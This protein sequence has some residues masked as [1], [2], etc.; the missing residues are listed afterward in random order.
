VDEGDIA[1]LL[2]VHATRWSVPGAALGILH[3]GTVSTACFGVA[4]VRSNDPVTS[5]T[6][7]SAGSLTKSIVATHLL[8]LARA[9][10]LTLDDPV[11]QHVPELRGARWASSVTVRDLMANRSGLPLRTSLEFGF[12]DRLDEDDGAL[13]RLV[14]DLPRDEAATRFWSYTNVGWCVL[15]RVIETVTGQSFEEALGHCLDDLGMRDTG[16]G[17]AV[18]ARARGHSVTETGVA[19]VE[20]LASKAYAPAG[21]RLVTTVTDL[22]AFARHHLDDPSLA[23]L[24]TLHSEVAIRGWLDG[25]GLGW[26]RFDWEGHEAWGW[27]GLV[28]GERAVLRLLP[29]QST[30]LVLLTNADTGRP[31]YRS[32][33]ADLLPSV[34]GVRVPPLPL[35]PVPGAAGDV[36]RYAGVY[37]WPDHRVE[38]TAAVD[39]LRIL[40]AERWFDAAPLDVRTFVVDP[41]DPD[42]PTVTFDGFDSSGRPQ[43][44]YDMLWGLPRV[45]P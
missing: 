5:T 22:L 36:D 38:V 4:D 18:A 41:A 17:E 30:A 12:D 34:T 3:R 15:G 39:G 24:R 8:G 29:D 44:L 33:F 1:E 35:D 37:A 42:T 2:Q 28:P 43:V 32:L 21:A 20:P 16:P 23:D 19:P 14:A 9:G 27:D 11:T 6:R 25:W 13:A 45:T 7:F 10:R 26:A 40:L 31:M